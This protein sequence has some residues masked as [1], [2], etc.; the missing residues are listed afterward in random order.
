MHIIFGHAGLDRE[1]EGYHGH[2]QPVAQD[3]G[4]DGQAYGKY[5]E[6]SGRP[7]CE[8]GGSCGRR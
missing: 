1:T 3:V 8:K 2:N 5:D 7:K 4:K 6:D